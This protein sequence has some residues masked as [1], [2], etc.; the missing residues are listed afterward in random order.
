M[1]TYKG[2]L[3]RSNGQHRPFILSRAFFTGSQRFGAVWTGDNTADWGHLAISIPML[4]T[5]SVTGMAFSGADVGG[6]FGNPDTELLVRWYQVKMK[7]IGEVKPLTLQIKN[8]FD[9]LELFNHFIVHTPI[10]I[11][12]AVNLGCLSPRLSGE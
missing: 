10:W 3:L 7:E 8:L 1:S 5:L 9:R 2:H 11:P 6:F 4:L 12:S